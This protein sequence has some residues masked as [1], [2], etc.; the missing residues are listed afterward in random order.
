M[1]RIEANEHVKK[2][3][4]SKESPKPYIRQR[5]YHQHLHQFH[6]YDSNC[7]VEK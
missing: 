7:V 3:T 2:K 5:T 1:T 4:L 6:E